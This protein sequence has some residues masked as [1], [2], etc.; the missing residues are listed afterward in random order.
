VSGASG[1]AAAPDGRTRIHWESTGDGPPVLL[2]MGLGLSGGAWWRTVPVLSRR[3]RVITFD[4]RGIGR[5][6]S[7]MP[8]Y[9]VEAMA[10]DAVSVIDALG[11]ES[12]HV[13]G[14]SL[15]GMIAQQVALR[16]PDRVRALVLGATHPGGRRVAHPEEEVV[17]FFRR[18]LAMQSEEAAWAS[19]PYN[20]GARC[21]A[22]QIDRIA[23]DIERRL[24]SP[25]SVRAYRAQ[26]YAASLHNCYGRL[27]RI[28]APTLVV[29]GGE[30]RMIPVANAHMLSERIPGAEL[31]VLEESG[32]LYPTDEAGIDAEI[33][34]F[35]ESRSD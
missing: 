6:E 32:H 27:G 16:H 19:V 14:F 12:V 5:S 28:A 22:S 8:A 20:Y 17:A 25:F 9:T 21:R 15:G 3:L 23:E 33:G 29:H 34:S 30:D 35:F 18:R 26:L 2:I 7:L 10:D 31:R 4:H 24:E 11:L 13:Y 1:I